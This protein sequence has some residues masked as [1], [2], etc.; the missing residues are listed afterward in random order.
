MKKCV[1][2]HSGVIE[3]RIS[4]RRKT[5]LKSRLAL[6]GWN[7]ATREKVFILSQR[8]MRPQ[9]FM[10]DFCAASKLCLT[11]LA[12]WRT[13]REHPLAGGKRPQNH[14]NNKTCKGTSGWHTIENFALPENF[15]GIWLCTSGMK[16]CYSW[17]GLHL[18]TKRNRA[19]KD[20]CPIALSQV[21]FA[22]CSWLASRQ[23]RSFE[24]TRITSSCKRWGT[25]TSQ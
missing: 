21:S 25:R 12:G 9:R 19:C 5:L 14:L 7:F 3:L 4:H 22:C 1:K 15:A 2:A 11:L 17:K 16:L 23:T 18:K 8:E 20:L 13:K 10:S 6:Q 24:E